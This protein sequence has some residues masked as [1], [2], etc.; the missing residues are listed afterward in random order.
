[1]SKNQTSTDKPSV[2][3]FVLAEMVRRGLDNFEACRQEL[4]EEIK[5]LRHDERAVPSLRDYLLQAPDMS[6]LDLA[7]DRSALRDLDL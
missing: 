5:R 4:L 7:R 3:H 2:E 6:D 1:M